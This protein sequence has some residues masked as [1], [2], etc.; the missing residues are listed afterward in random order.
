M[1]ISSGGKGNELR[2]GGK[3]T[4]AHAGP[5]W[6]PAASNGKESAASH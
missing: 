2:G 1:L 4:P 6:V 5:Y 3:G